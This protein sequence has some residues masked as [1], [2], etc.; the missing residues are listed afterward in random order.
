MNIGLAVAETASVVIVPAVAGAFVSSRLRANLFVTL[1][2]L[3]AGYYF[4][5]MAVSAILY[6]IAPFGLA[7]LVA[8][9][10][11]SLCVSLALF[12]TPLAART[13]PST[14]YWGV[15]R[16]TTTLALLMVLACGAVVTDVLIFARQGF[17][18]ADHSSLF[19]TA[20]TGDMQ[21]DTDIIAA[22][23]RMNQ[24]PF[25]P[26]APLLYQVL[27]HHGG[28]NLIALLP[29]D[30]TD[31]GYVLG[32]ALFTGWLFYFMLLWLVVLIR[33]SLALLP[34][35]L[36][37]LVIL[38]GTDGDLY[39][40]ALSF[41]QRGTIG[42]A[43]DASSTV[44][45][46][47]RY[48]SNKLVS[49]SSPQHATFFILFV[50]VI[51]CTYQRASSSVQHS[52]L[53]A[54]SLGLASLFGAF[55]LVADTVLAL[56]VLPLY[57]LVLLVRTPR[58]RLNL[59]V[60]GVAALCGGFALHVAILRFSPID[61]LFRPI[62][63]PETAYALKLAWQLDQPLGVL[64]QLPFVFVATG[65][66]CGALLTAVLVRAAIRNR[67]LFAD[68]LVVTLLVGTLLWNVLAVQTELQR[69]FSMIAAFL[70]LLVIAI[71][72]TPLERIHGRVSRV[73]GGTIGVACA[74]TALVLN[75]HLVQSYTTGGAVLD[76][77]I[78]W[79]DYFCTNKV[80]ARDHPNMA[81]I[82]DTPPSFELPIAT[83]GTTALVWSQVAQVHQRMS[84]RD[85]ESLEAINPRGAGRF[86][87][88]VLASPAA[89][90]SELRRMGFRGVIWGPVEESDWGGDV[91]T[92]LAR[93]DGFL[94]ACG[95]VALYSLA[96]DALD[97]NTAGTRV[98]ESDA[99]VQALVDRKERLCSASPNTDVRVLD[100]AVASPATTT[101]VDSDVAVGK[102]AR[103]SSTVGASDARFA[104]DGDTNGDNTKVAI[105]HTMN[106]RDPWWEVDLEGSQRIDAVQLWN[107]TDC[108]QDRLKDVYVLISEQPF[109]STK[110][111]PA[112]TQAG[113]TAF[114]LSG[115]VPD[116]GVRI[117][118]D[119]AG[120]YV[121]VQ[122][123]RQGFLA[124]AEVQVLAG[125]LQ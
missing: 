83:E 104:V 89:V 84:A 55:C 117:P 87:Q 28:A 111:F 100:A 61:L 68:P 60:A 24:A 121:R 47:F 23:L 32:F 9:T 1:P 7:K 123:A 91:R 17:S 10:A 66:V 99:F 49:L 36:V 96:P 22:L 59:L 33:P 54:G 79:Q 16:A 74:L 26:D 4:C 30:F 5:F 114:F 93:P 81:V 19:A 67:R 122:L 78:P 41:L 38:A 72:V 2:I 42:L 34:I 92:I 11:I 85:A 15:G 45:S 118:V 20:F 56:L 18:V 108:C 14:K 37:L 44:P 69:H 35:T 113:V 71:A 124:L 6:G 76:L 63:T 103:Q 109:A 50:T 8:A 73:V 40:G 27:W 86:K 102:S 106:D 51:A 107:R 64:S 25:F 58:E 52:G 97:P 95:Q 82:V 105:A 29:A 53:P 21:R 90:T 94:E 116:S 3:L 12:A 75:A 115:Q 101:T 65:G 119:R 70:T 39:N 98:G 88:A 112:C 77:S 43:A 125:A 110:P 46:E 62:S 31:F 57:L 120:R 48:F 13:S 80:I